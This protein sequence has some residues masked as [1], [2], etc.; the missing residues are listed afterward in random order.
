MSAETKKEQPAG[1]LRFLNKSNRVNKNVLAAAILLPVKKADNDGDTQALVNPW[2]HIKGTHGTIT[3]P[4][5]MLGFAAI[6]ETTSELNQCVTAYEINIPGFGWVLKPEKT[7]AEDAKDDEVFAAQVEEEKDNFKELLTYV[8]YDEQSFTKL[9]RNE[10][11]EI[12]QSGNSYLEVIRDSQGVMCALRLIPFVSMR[13]TPRSSNPVLVERQ[14]PTGKGK[15]RKL[16]KVKVWRRF[17]RYV[18]A[19]AGSLGIHKVIYFKQY[20]DPRTLN[21]ETGEFVDDPNTLDKKKHATEVIH[22]R[23]Y[24]SRS[25]YGM[26]RF[27]GN[28]LAVFGSRKAEEINFTTFT[29]NNIPSMMLLVTNGEVTEESMA[30]IK[31]FTETV[32]QGTDNMSKILLVEAFSTD[33]ESDNAKIEIK[34]LTK[35]QHTDEMFQAYDAN[36][37]EKVRES[38]RIPPLLVG[39]STDYNRATSESSR[40]LAEEQ[41][42]SPERNEDDHFFNRLLTDEGMFLNVFKTNTPNVTNDQDLINVMNGAEKSGGMTPR[43]SRMILEDVLNVEL[44]DFAPDFDP[45]IPF[46]LSMAEK[47]K[48]MGKPNEVGQQVTALKAAET[49][50][51]W[52]DRISNAV[53]LNLSESDAEP[54]TDIALN[55]GS[56]AQDISDGLQ[57]GYVSSIQLNLEGREMMLSDGVVIFGKAKFGEVKKLGIEHAATASGLEVDDLR[58]MYPGK[59]EL[60]VADI[61]A[62][63]EIDPITYE[64]PNDSL[65]AVVV[66]V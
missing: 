8:D 19:R 51:S 40:A 17:R 52:Y 31:T 4:Y 28:L 39:R 64:H 35:E 26:P 18:Q 41:V 29:N 49:D 25:P 36:N 30:R 56:Q 23:I 59:F 1:E 15:D 27:I 47:V 42:F 5:D 50:A 11:R 22:R 61:I 16:K 45:D 12:E 53:I 57:L 10:R 37:R 32:I 3:P 55:A 2:N 60:Y 7:V 6:M 9:R 54:S 14:R 43:I 65:F 13:V 66:N 34:P 33:D 24:N 38:F 48:N 58:A 21:K 62:R 63:E 46:S 44:P 20:G